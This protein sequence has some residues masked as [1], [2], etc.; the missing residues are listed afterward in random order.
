LSQCLDS[1]SGVQTPLL[2]TTGELDDQDFSDVAHWLDGLGVALC[3]TDATGQS[4]IVNSSHARIT[5]SAG[6]GASLT[7]PLADGRTLQLRAPADRVE[8]ILSDS[9]ARYRLLADHSS[10]LIV[11]VDADLAIRY[12]SPAAQPMLGW[13]A[14]ELIGHTLA[15]LLLPDE[16]ATFIARHFTKSARRASGPDLFRALRRDGHALWV[17]ARVAPL[18]PGGGLGSFVVTLRDAERRKRAEQALA[19]ANLELSALAATDALTNMPNRREFDA[20]LTK[21]WYRA[22]R[23]G[24]PLALLMIDIDHFKSLND[25]FGHQVGDAFLAAVAQV[26]RQ[27]VRRAGDL[28]ARYGGEEFAVILPGT[29]VTGAL[30]IADHIRRAVLEADFTHVIAGG[31]NVSVSVGVAASVPIS[32]GGAHTLVDAADHALYEAKRNGRNRVEAL[33]G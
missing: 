8:Q 16:R 24:V 7:L 18:P 29:A 15:E 28:A 20:T 25:R 14:Y 4:T 19:L 1:S 2:N 22:L 11:A 5:E 9:E 33:N 26:I 23:D 12:A 30:E 17:E 3:V 21:E 13:H 10:D 32:G 27:N 31:H 6:S